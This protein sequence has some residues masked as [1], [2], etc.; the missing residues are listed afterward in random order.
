MVL[1]ADQNPPRVVAPIEEEYGLLGVV[2]SHIISPLGCYDRH[3]SND[4][5]RTDLA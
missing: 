5:S 1:L 4:G 2:A 3:N